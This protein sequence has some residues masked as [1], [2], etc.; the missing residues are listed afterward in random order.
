MVIITLGEC[1][2]QYGL[3]KRTGEGESSS[4]YRI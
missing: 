4:I 2:S 3:R 1:R